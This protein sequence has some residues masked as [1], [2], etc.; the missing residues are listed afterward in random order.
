MLPLSMNLKRLKM[1]DMD[2]RLSDFKTWFLSLP[3]DVKEDIL[4]KAIKQDF[5]YY[6]SLSR[7][8]LDAPLDQGG[9]STEKLDKIVNDKL[10]QN[11]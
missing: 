4:I 6:M 3:E 7:I 9:M 2:T 8:L 1:I 10:K 5:S 11:D